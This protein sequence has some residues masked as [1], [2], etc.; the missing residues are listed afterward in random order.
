MGIP[1]DDLPVGRGKMI[2]RIAH[3]RENRASRDLRQ[4]RRRRAARFLVELKDNFLLPR[5]QKFPFCAII[6]ES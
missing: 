6:V 5:R 2:S 4:G 1:S 3:R